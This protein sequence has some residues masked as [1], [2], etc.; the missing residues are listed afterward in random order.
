MLLKNLIILGIML[1]SAS[2]DRSRFYSSTLTV[3]GYPLNYSYFTLQTGGELK[4]IEENSNGLPQRS[5]PFRVRLRREGEELGQWSASQ[6][7]GVY[8]FSLNKLWP[9]A[10]VGDELVV[11]PV[12]RS[13]VGREMPVIKLKP[14]NLLMNWMVNFSARDRRDGC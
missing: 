3:N 12:Q 7:G 13:V 6:T 9:L 4:L 1:L 11:E 14:V 10:Q 2:H 5:V 8:S